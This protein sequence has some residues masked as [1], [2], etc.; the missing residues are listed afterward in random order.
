MFS[1]HSPHAALLSKVSLCWFGLLVAACSP[2]GDV[3]MFL[4]DGLRPPVVT[5][6]RFTSA[7][8]IEISCDTPLQRAALRTDPPT[9]IS[10]SGIEGDMAWF[11]LAEEVAIGSR[12][13]LFAALQGRNGHSAQVMRWAYGYNPRPVD[14]ILNEVIMRG[15]GNN[16]DCLE[17]LVRS[18]G[19]LGG[20]AWYL[21]TSAVHDA[22]YIFPAVE[23][24]AGDY[25]I[26]HVRPEGLPEEQD[27]LGADLALSGG[28]QS[29]PQAR[30][31]WLPEAVGLPSNNGV[32]TLYSSPDGELLDALLYSNRSS[33]SDTAYRGFGTTK[34]L[35]WVDSLAEQGGWIGEYE[36]LRPEDAV[37]PEGSTG[38]RSV[39]RRYPPVVTRSRSD[40]H[41][42]PTLG[43]TMGS[44]NS[45]EIYEP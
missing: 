30:D 40:W 27:E 45:N 4:T 5:T 34:M 35:G 1:H 7:T 14:M 42:V 10:D 38:T 8:R 12:Y 36:L 39:N 17:F 26:L 41:I 29:H 23:V 21:G 37:S 43:A 13:A 16:P 2:Y 24:A 19:N 15:S 32:L 44:Q 31:L 33:A 6:V 3:Q 25:I 28:K 9:V 18:G 20:T 22:A 11:E